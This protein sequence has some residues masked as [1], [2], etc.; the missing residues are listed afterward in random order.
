MGLPS[1][2]RSVIDR[3][4]AMRRMTIH[5][6]ISAGTTGPIQCTGLSPYWFA[7]H[8]YLFC[9]HLWH[10]QYTRADQ[11]TACALHWCSTQVACKNV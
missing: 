1:Y 3:N 9:P 11:S 7:T 10:I 6:T 4:V 8:A 2:M 5:T